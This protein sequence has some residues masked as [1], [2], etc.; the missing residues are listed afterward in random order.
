M[1]LN[2]LCDPRSKLDVTNWKAT[3]HRPQFWQLD[4]QHF[5]RSLDFLAEN[6]DKIEV[7]LFDRI[8]NLFNLELDLVFWNPT[9][10]YFGGKVQRTLLNTV[11][12][13]TTARTGYR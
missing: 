5:Y 8:K 12:P 10:T 13:K 11:S 4:L 6:K 1:V 3:V 7:Q 2:R 9:S